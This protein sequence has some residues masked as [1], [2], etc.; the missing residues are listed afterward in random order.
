MDFLLEKIIAH[1]GLHSRDL[2]IPENSMGAFEAAIVKG[3]PIEL[4]IHKTADGKT[5][6]FHDDNLKRMTGMD[7][8]IKDCTYDELKALR[9][10]GTEYEIPLLSDVFSLVG[11]RV[12]LLVEVKTDLRAGG[13]E[14][15]F[16]KEAERYKGEYAVQ[17]F[18]PFSLMWFKKNAPSVPRGQLSSYF[19]G[20][21]LAALKKLLLKNMYL[22]PLTK[23]DFI[24]YNIDNMP[25]RITD[26]IKE[27]GIPL[28]GWTVRNEL[29]FR[30]MRNYC[31]SIIFENFMPA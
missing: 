17:S 31:D 22:N 12:P 11:G 19:E 14:A 7:K 10:G 3:L 1:R 26:K 6:V 8:R 5:V 28:F 13:T 18:S 23:P 29:D 4:D 16:M 2:K 24:S 27:A 9:L 30:R 25:G 21:R 15:C 20:D